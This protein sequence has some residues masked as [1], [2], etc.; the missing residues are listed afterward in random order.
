VVLELT[1]GRVLSGVIVS[2][3]DQELRLAPNPLDP[4]SSQEPIVVPAGTVA[5][6]FPSAVSLMPQGLLNTLEEHEIVDL[7]SYVLSGG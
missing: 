5:E 2:Q 7:L 4:Q 1:D 3:N 6:R